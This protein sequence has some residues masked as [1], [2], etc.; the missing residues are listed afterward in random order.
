MTASHDGDRRSIG[1]LLGELANGGAR[2][3]RGEL[4]LT[5]LE[6]AEL[7]RRVGVGTIEVALG[8]VLFAIGGVAVVTGLILLAGDQWF[9][10]D[11]YWIAGLLATVFF[12]VVAGWTAMRGA[13]LLSL[14]RLAPDE[15]VTTLKEGKEWL[16]RR[17]T[18]GATSS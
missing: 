12:V 7:V 5:R 15:T 9:P 16:R 13:D 10:N 11:R 2:L 1:S 18:S 8:G 17:L 4:E 3:A 14:K 6:V